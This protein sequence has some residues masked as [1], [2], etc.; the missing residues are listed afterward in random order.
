[1]T[2]W[3]Q[4]ICNISSAVKPS[5][6]YPIDTHNLRFVTGLHYGL[7]SPV[8]FDRTEVVSKSSQEG[9]D[10]E[11]PKHDA[12][13]HGNLGL[14]SCGRRAYVECESDCD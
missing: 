7:F 14:E 2:R 4:S 3:Q 13:W 1:M 9:Q 10:C 6:A 8:I 12:Q 5:D 11:D